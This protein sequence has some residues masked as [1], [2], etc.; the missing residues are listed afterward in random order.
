MKTIEKDEILKNS[1]DSY[2][3]V[4][5]EDWEILC[6]ISREDWGYS[7]YTLEQYVLLKEDVYK[8]LDKAAG[9]E[10]IDKIDTDIAEQYKDEAKIEKYLEKT[11]E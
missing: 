5:D 3:V 9:I 6:M 11:E 7:A 8:I 2:I 10:L 4:R 1:V